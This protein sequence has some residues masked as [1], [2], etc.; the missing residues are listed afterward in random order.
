M[1]KNCGCQEAIEK[2]RFTP[3]L[4][5]HHS[6]LPLVT[7]DL[8]RSIALEY[9]VLAKNDEIAR[10]NR[11]WFAKY[12]IRVLNLMSSP[13][14]GKTKLLEETAKQVGAQG[15]LS[16]LTGDV[17]RDFDAKRLEKAGARVKQINTLNSCHLSA[18]QIKRELNEF[19]RPE[20]GVLIIENVG[21]LVCP[22][23]FDL[24]Q[25]SRVAMLSTTEG[26]DKPAK[27]PLLF[28]EADLIVVSKMD[29]VPHL[30]WSPQLCEKYIRQVNGRAPIFKL[31]AKTGEGMSSW[32][33]YLQS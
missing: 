32:I 10:E 11:N 16:I 3:N 26:E 28:Q 12:G 23:A 24:G 6:H 33:Q 30:D 5:P 18:E 1:C 9:S 14:S 4:R 29:L 2:K 31:S 27:Y 19:V 17:E 7:F 20:A 21:N 15:R 25:T 8:P 22:A 13:G